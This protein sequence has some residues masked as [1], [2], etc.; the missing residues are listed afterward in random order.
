MCIVTKMWRS[1]FAGEKCVTDLRLT[2][3]NEGTSSGFPNL[4]DAVD[5]RP[6]MTVTFKLNYREPFDFAGLLKFFELRAIPGVEQVQ[7]PADGAA[8]E[9]AAAE[10]VGSYER[11]FVADG[12]PGLL[13]VKQA[14][15]SAALLCRV[16]GGPSG[17]LQ[18]VS[19]SLRRQFDVDAHP[20]EISRVLSQDKIMEPLVA[21][22]PGQRLPGAFDAFETCVRAIVGQQ[23]SV[24][25]ATTVMGRI[26][27]RYGKA[28]AYGRVFPSAQVLADIDPASLAMPRRRAAAI[29]AF[30]RCIA[31]GEISFD[32]S[33]E[34]F[35]EAVLA[36][37]GIGPW[38]SQYMLLRVYGDPD[39]F[40]VGDLV[41]RKS[42]CG[43]LGINSERDLLAHSQRWRPWRGYA[44]MHLWRFA[45]TMV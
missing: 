32:R 44:G 40:L 31:T 17:S 42:A 5:T 15:E 26:A 36:V 28:T 30:S 3:L 13:Q 22:N 23:V 19:Q 1:Y 43:L 38:T 34:E 41:I 4:K 9:S 37:P 7:R 21:E 24:V 25:A 20:D 29:V 14:D 39:A 35:A 2:A 8:A 27:D 12:E 6:D 11:S 33:A 45:S 18:S 16:S 10:S